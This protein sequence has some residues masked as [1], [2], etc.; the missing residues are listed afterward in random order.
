MLRCLAE[1]ECGTSM[2]NLS[3]AHSSVTDDGLILA[4]ERCRNLSTLDVSVEEYNS[5]PNQGKVTDR[6]VDV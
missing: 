1:A 6:F 2:T 4:L 5:E 3:A